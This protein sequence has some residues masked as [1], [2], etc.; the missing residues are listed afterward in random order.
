M[1]RPSPRSSGNTVP[2]IALILVSLAVGILVPLGAAELLLR[3]LPVSEGLMPTPVN[4]SN[5][6]FHFTPNRTATW[7]RG[8]D[9]SVVNRLRVNNAGYVN[10]QDYTQSDHRPLF[11]VVG[12]SYVE[13]AM[14]PYVETLQGHL[15]QLADPDGRVYSFAASGAPLSQYLIWAREA[16]L[17]WKAQALAIVVI[18]NDFDQSLAAY[19]AGPGFHHYVEDGA[20]QLTLRRFDYQPG[21]KRNV[22]VHSALLKYLLI[23]LKVLHHLTRLWGELPSFGAA[24]HAEN[25]V[26]NTS[27]TTGKRRIERSKAA[28]RA[29][30]RDLVSFAGWKPAQ[31]VFVVDGIRYPSS[32]PAVLGSYF[33][34]MRTFFMSEARQS[35]FEVIDMDENFFARHPTDATAFQFKDDRHWNGLAHG[36][37]ADAVAESAVFSRWRRGFTPP[38][39]P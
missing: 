19:K 1:N 5:P 29:F 15:A 35:E 7:S 33:M 2:K 25:F 34:Q 23:N 11:A 27:A 20:G 26:G 13:A 38:A 14:V 36:I 28:I 30:L 3:F 21:W 8:W 24:A 12:D 39:R 32:K 10:N 22:A 6:V 37:A 17:S 4:E 18:S 31:V 16:R 9:F